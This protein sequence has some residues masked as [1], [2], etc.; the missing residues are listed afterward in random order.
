M[1][2]PSRAL[3]HRFPGAILP[4]YSL[5]GELGVRDFV[6]G[7]LS[8]FDAL[9]AG[10]LDRF[11]EFRYRRRGRRR[12]AGEAIAGVILLGALLTL[13]IFASLAALGSEESSNGPVA[14]SFSSS[15]FEWATTDVVT[16]TITRDGKT[17]RIVRRRSSQGD[18]TSETIT[19]RGTTVQGALIRDTRTVTTREVDT[20]TVRQQVTVID[21][22]TVTVMETVTVTTPGPPGDDG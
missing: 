19:A 11:D 2:W 1:V 10:L 8:R 22:V 13:G 5:V 9:V 14:Q 12:T 7:L 21:P 3:V 15:G 16:E 6:A 20:V 4:P 17:V 18:A